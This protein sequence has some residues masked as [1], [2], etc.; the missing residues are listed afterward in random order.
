MMK[1]MDP[2]QKDEPRTQG[3]GGRPE[4]SSNYPPAAP[5]AILVFLL[6]QEIPSYK[7]SHIPKVH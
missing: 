1:K 3:T 5:K 2:L 6:M 7:Q 4:T